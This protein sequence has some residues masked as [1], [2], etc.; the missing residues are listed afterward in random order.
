[1]SNVVESSAGF[2]VR[3]ASRADV[4]RDPVRVPLPM[5]TWTKATRTFCDFRHLMDSSLS[6]IIAQVSL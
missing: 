4:L 6:R 2:M 5:S 1:M 3:G